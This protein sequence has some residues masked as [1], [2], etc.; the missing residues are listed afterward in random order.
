MRDDPPPG[1]GCEPLSASPRYYR[2]VRYRRIV[3]KFGT[4]L[5]TAGSDRLDLVAMSQLVGQVDRLRSAGHEVVVV[6]SGARAA[7][8]H[9][10][11]R[12]LPEG[13][14]PSRQA[15][16]SVGQG[17]LMQSWD[18]LFEWHDTIVAQVLLTRRDLSDRQGYLNARN[19]LRHLL[20][21]GTVPIVNENDAVAL[22]EVLASRIGENDSL[23]AY[24]ANL[25]D[26]DLLVIL[27]DVDGFFDDDPRKN[28]EAKLV[29]RVEHV[30]IEVE[31][32]AKGVGS[33]AG[34][35]GMI[36]KL[37][38]ANIAAQSG[39]D[40]VVANGHRPGA[41]I[42]AAEGRE[43]GTLFPAIGD[44]IEGRK[45]WLLAN[46]A[47]TGHIVV[48]PGAVEALR[49]RGRSL[50]PA[51][52]ASVA[53]TFARGDTVEVRAPDGSLAAAGTTNYDSAD[54]TRIKGMRSDR[55][56]ETLG[57]AYADEVIH[58]DNLVLL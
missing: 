11:A 3:A 39:V 27:T 43:P 8:R 40:V 7:G 52:V 1:A 33:F 24:V 31:S 41:L 2:L 18:Q 58:R 21:M 44:R 51:G 16:A 29:K 30:D 5:L 57:Y 56:A 42:D 28:P 54:V 25:I 10:L 23:A 34:S 14:V 6:S 36:T 15:V 46:I 55:I 13:F 22:D 17:Q 4:S 37:K 9:R 32:A 35:G 50:L 47:R 48:D 53:G 49:A 20:E 38:A 45:R 26:A 12:R 19:T